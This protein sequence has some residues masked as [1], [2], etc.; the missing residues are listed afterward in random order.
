MATQP[1]R[2]RD[3]ARGHAAWLEWSRDVR[4]HDV[5]LSLSAWPVLKLGGT[6]LQENPIITTPQSTDLE[7]PG[8][9]RLAIRGYRGGEEYVGSTSA[10]F[11]EHESFG[12]DT[13][14]T[15]ARANH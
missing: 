12:A 7:S 14:R 13:G 2:A 8:K 10:I 9:N 6:L 4:N 1:M 11:G 3:P 15:R 5:V